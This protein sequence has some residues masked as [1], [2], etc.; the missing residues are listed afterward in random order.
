M[1]VIKFGIRR[2]QAHEEEARKEDGT[3]DYNMVK[4]KDKI[5]HK[6]RAQIVNDLVK[7]YD[8]KF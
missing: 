2:I 6:E 7:K 5:H 8:L 3:V 4:Q 1:S